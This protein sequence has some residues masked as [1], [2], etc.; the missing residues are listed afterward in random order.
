MKMG[1][2][3]LMVGAAAIAMVASSAQAADKDAAQRRHRGLAQNRQL[4]GICN[5]EL[6]ARVQALEDAQADATI[7]PADRTRLSTL[8]QSYNYAVWTFDNGRADLRHRR[9]P[10]HHGL[11]VRFQTD[12]AGFSQDSTHPRRLR[13]PDRPVL[14]RRDAPRLFRHRRQGL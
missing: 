9:R 10:L 14:R 1:K 11:R 5:A 8:E 6:A 12:F 4:G 13:R 3:G 2:I 7:A